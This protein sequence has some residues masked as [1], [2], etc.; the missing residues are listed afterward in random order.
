MRQAEVLLEGDDNAYYCI[1]PTG[2]CGQGKSLRIFHGQESK[3]VLELTG[4]WSRDSWRYIPA[5]YLRVPLF[6]TCEN[7]RT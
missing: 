5:P 1:F 7:L 3:G 6:D 4:V 2:N